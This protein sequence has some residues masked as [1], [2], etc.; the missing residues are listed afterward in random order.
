MRIEA[1]NRWRGDGICALLGYYA[2][3]SGNFHRRF[4]TTYQSHL[5]G[6]KIPC[7]LKMVRIGCPEP[8][9]K[10]YRYTLRIPVERRLLLLHGGS[11]KWSNKR[12]SEVRC[13]NIFIDLQLGKWLLSCLLF[14]RLNFQFHGTV[15]SLSVQ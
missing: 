13:K 11:L 5:Q 14:K 7:T 8:S 4:G 2:A 10:N 3:R 6:S 15:S 9:V 1:G 12:M